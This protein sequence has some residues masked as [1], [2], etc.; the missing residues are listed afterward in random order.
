M[1]IWINIQKVFLFSL[2][3]IALFVANYSVA[4][5]TYSPLPKFCVVLDAGHGGV[6]T[7]AVSKNGTFERDI[8]LQITQKLGY[9]LTAMGITVIYTRTTQ[10][11]LFN[12]FSHGHKLKDMKA[13][14]E[15]IKNANPNLVISIHLNSFTD[16]SAHGAQVFFKPHDEYSQELSQHIQDIFLKNIEGSRKNSMKGDFYILNYSPS[17]AILIECGFLSNPEEERLLLSS[18]YQ[19]KL[20]YLIMCGIV[21]Y[22]GLAEF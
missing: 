18:T 13:R 20:A 21:S 22:F 6:D 16:S 2:I 3:F 8:N 11:A 17:A 1:V 7:G 15:I 12:T 14:T 10:D 4:T 9:M 19:E 5:Y